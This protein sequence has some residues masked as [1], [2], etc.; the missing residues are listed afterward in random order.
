MFVGLCKSPRMMSC[1]NNA[2]YGLFRP[3]VA[4]ITR[5]N[6]A[7]FFCSNELRM[8]RTVDVQQPLLSSS[9]TG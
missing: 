1:S 9:D 3:N 7:V 5:T 6:L 8:L 2:I 4:I